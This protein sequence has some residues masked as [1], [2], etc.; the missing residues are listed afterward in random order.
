MYTLVHL[1]FFTRSAAAM[2]VALIESQALGTLAVFGA[3]VLA[4]AAVAVTARVLARV[5]AV[6]QSSATADRAEE[7]P[8]ILHLCSQD[9]PTADGHPRPRAPGWATSVAAH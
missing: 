7:P 5:A 3:I 8:P 6:L 1:P 2:F 4:G 9:D